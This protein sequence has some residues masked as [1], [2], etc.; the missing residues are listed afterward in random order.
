MA[1]QVEIANRALTK[2]GEA[3]ITALTDNVEAAR[4]I[5]SMWDMVRDAELRARNWNFSITR[6]SLAALVTVPAFRFLYEFQLPSLCLKVIQVG[7]FYPG[8]SMSDYRNASESEYQIEGRKILTNYP[9]PLYIRYVS[10][11]TDTGQWD[12]LFAEAFACKLAM[13]ACEKLTQS[14]TKR[15]LADG[16]YDK[17]IAAAVRSDAVE[18]PPE[19]L[20]DDA[21]LLSRL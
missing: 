15:Q 5:S 14:N 12:A 6:T 10:S 20:P 9:A 21:W 7:E 8:P 13:E 3:R 16:E 18:N 19:P 2:I 11:I 1:S 4:V 17:A